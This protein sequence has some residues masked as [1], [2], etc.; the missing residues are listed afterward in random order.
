MAEATRYLQI[1]HR[2]LHNWLSG[3]PYLT[4]GGRCR[5][6]PVVDIADPQQHLLSFLNMVEL[7]VLDAIRNVNGLDLRKIRRALTY[8]QEELGVAHPLA[9]QQMETDGCTLFVERL[10]Q[11]IDVAR[12]GQTAMH[13]MLGMRLKR[14]ERDPRGIAIKLFLFTRRK[15]Q[16]VAEA[17]RAPQVVALDPAVAFGRPVIVG[18]RIPTAEVASRYKAGD[19]IGQLA[20]DYGRRQEEIEEAIRCE[21]HLDAA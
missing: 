6:E 17:E 10:D 9:D 12:E 16:D 14:I 21:L 15:P 19:S 8:L 11:L 5:S 4:K 2:T 3:V 13:Q 20:Q 1:P 7:H 18:S